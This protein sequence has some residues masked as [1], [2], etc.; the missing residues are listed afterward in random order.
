LF[1]WRP[2]GFVDIH[3]L[4]GARFGTCPQNNNRIPQP[5]HDLGRCEFDSVIRPA[6]P[7][8]Q[9][10]YMAISLVH[11]CGSDFLDAHDQWR[12]VTSLGLIRI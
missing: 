2:I 8:E 4:W 12:G 6:F 11:S 1:I 7:L 9:H 3:I 10:L 5:S